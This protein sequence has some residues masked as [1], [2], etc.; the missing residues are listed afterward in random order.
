TVTNSAAYIKEYI[1]K[2]I[3]RLG[4]TADL[5]YLHIIDPGVWRYRVYACSQHSSQNIKAIVIEIKKL[6]TREVCVIAQIALAWLAAQGLISILGKTKVTFGRES[7]ILDC[8]I[9]RTRGEGMRK[10]MY[11]TKPIGERF[12][13]NMQHLVGN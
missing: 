8:R 6:A 1:K 4:F 3:K 2:T 12:A 10:I 7:G 5:Y 11:D 9:N 13:A